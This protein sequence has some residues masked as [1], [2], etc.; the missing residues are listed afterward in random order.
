VVALS[1]AVSRLDG[2]GTSEADW[3]NC[4]PLHRLRPWVRPTPATGRCLIVAPHPDDETLGVGGTSSLLFAAGINLV[5]LAVTDGENSHPGRR[6]ELR[7]RRPVEVAAA[8]ARLGI[9]P[10]RTVRLGHPDGSIAEPRLRTQLARLMRPGDLVLAPWDRDG[11]PDH[12]RVGRAARVVADQRQAQLLCYLVWAWHWA[13]PDGADLP[14][15]RSARV[16]LGPAL[17][18]RK[19]QAVRCF[20][21]Q[22]TGADPILPAAIIE[23]LTRPYEVLLGP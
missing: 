5:L 21:T 20:A 22:L 1:A 13:S 17:T 8:A 23:R 2:P 4:A 15:D 10:V 14:W 9:A 16:E 19:R 6:A 3:Q 18:R 11:H 12:N 7:R